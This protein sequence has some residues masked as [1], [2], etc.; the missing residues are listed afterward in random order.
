MAAPHS[1][2]R[3]TPLERAPLPDLD[4]ALIPKER[5]ISEAF[6]GR[7]RERLWTR[8]WLMAGFESD[9]AE[10]GDYFTFEIGRESVLVVRQDDAGI[11]AFH[12]VCMHRG[13]RLREPGQG[14]PAIIEHS[15][16]HDVR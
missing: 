9:L 4:H 14:R 11:Q 10:P 3:R 5:Y 8:V 6:A 15:T 12:N 7:E 1:S 16:S 2:P 13:N